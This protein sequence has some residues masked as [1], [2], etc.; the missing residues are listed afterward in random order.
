MQSKAFEWAVFMDKVLRGAGEE[1]IRLRKE[2]RLEVTYKSAGELVTTADLASDQIIRDAIAQSYPEHRILSEEKDSEDN[3]KETFEGPLW[4]IDPLDGTV[5]Y[6]KNLPHFAISAAIAV[7]GVVWAGVVHAPDLGVTYVGVKGGGAHCN[8]KQLHIK[9]FEPLSLAIV[10]TGFPH[11]KQKVHQ[12]NERVNLLTNSCMDIRRLAA[13]AIDICYVASGQ[14][15]AHT[16]TLAPWD[17]AAAGLIAREAGAITGHV[18]LVPHGVPSELYGEE[19]ICS[20]PGIYEELLE[21]LR[22]S[23]SLK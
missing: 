19:I 20:N 10:G 11:D 21:L 1:I 6:A 8:T 13:P 2:V 17:I 4:I 18:G 15:D 12:A 22:S 14:L 16:E 3:D 9:R 5:N 23:K 7:D